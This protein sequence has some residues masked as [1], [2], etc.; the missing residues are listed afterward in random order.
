MVRA[1]AIVRSGSV[2][3]STESHGER[4][5]AVFEH[6]AIKKHQRSLEEKKRQLER[7][8]AEVHSN[9]TV[10][11]D[12][13]RVT[14]ARGRLLHFEPAA[15][16]EFSVPMDEETVLARKMT[17][18]LKR[19]IRANYLGA[20]A[21]SVEEAA[22]PDDATTAATAATATTATTASAVDDEL[23]ALQI[24]AIMLQ[25]AEDSKRMHTADAGR[26]ASQAMSKLLTMRGEP[27][28]A[29]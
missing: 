24:R 6:R 10:V 9:L 3:G 29:K 27:T 12:L 7:A 8:L 22:E 28:I 4:S 25:H 19:T 1:G 2:H 20:A 17:P 5:H 14:R 15:D 16:V 13:Q 26:R 23:L 21:P 18:E 11:H